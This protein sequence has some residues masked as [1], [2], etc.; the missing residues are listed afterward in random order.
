M[1]PRSDPHKMR[2]A[3]LVFPGQPPAMLPRPLLPILFACLLTATWAAGAERMV[4]TP[5]PAPTAHANPP[6]GLT[7]YY[8]G[9]ITRGPNFNA[10]DQEDRAKIQTAHLANIERLAALGKLLVAGPF[11]DNGEWRGVFIFKCGSLEEALA[12]ASSDPAVQTGRLKVEIH[13]WMTAKGAIRD[14]EFATTK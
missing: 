10:Y 9:L 11:A 13:P 12:L 7:T 6:D 2:L 4:R 14:P 5:A 1:K 8:F 3:R